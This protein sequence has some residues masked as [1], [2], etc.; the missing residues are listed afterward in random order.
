MPTAKVNGIKMYYE[1]YGEGEPLVLIMGYGGHIGQWFRTIPALSR[2]YHVIAFDNR[3]AGRSEKAH[4]SYTLG[5]MS[6]DVA[7]L[8]DAI[9]IKAAHIYGVSMG[10]CIAQQFALDYPER[11][12]SLILGCT[13][14]GFVHFVRLEQPAGDTLHDYEHIKQLTP[15]ER[16]REQ[17]DFLFTEDFLRGNRDI[18]EQYIEKAVEY[19]TPVRCLW[20]QFEAIMSSDTYARLHEINCPTLVICGDSDKWVSPENARQ[21]AS[22]IPG[23]ELVMMRGQGHGFF[24]EAGDEAGKIILDF[25]RWNRRPS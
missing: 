21:L 12:N 1:T 19:P 22:R 10:G 24:I 14:S 18:V 9:G 3:G 23:A 7:G 20:H 16:E 6:N 5:M 8:L 17:L 11:V 25:L 4:G 15:E 2:N 13:H